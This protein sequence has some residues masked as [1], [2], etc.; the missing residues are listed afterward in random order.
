MG[1]DTCGHET[2]K[3]TPCQHPVTEGDSCWIPSHGGNADNHGRPKLLDDPQ[4]RQRILVAVGQGL[5]VCDQAAL[6]GIS[7][8]TL[9]RGLCCV[10]TPRQPELDSNP[11]DFCADYAQA[12]AN[13]AREVLQ[14]CRPEFVA[15]A[16]YGY[17]K[18]E[19]RELEHSGPDGESPIMVIDR[20]DDDGD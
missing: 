20:G 18:E 3:G 7:P 8:D 19:K 17:V 5:K 4:T 9:R 1:D 13:G 2:A 6:A 15:S 16:S 14:D 12:H 10:E 11:C